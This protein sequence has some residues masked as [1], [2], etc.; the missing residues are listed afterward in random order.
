MSAAGG[1]GPDNAD[2]I[3]LERPDVRVFRYLRLALVALAVTSTGAQAD[4]SPAVGE[5]EG[6]RLDEYRSPTPATLAGAA[7][8]DTEAL[9]RLLASRDDVLLIDVLPAPR[10]PKDLRPSALW[11][12][13]TRRNIPGS[14]WLPNTGYGVLPAEEDEYFRRNLRRLTGDHMDHPLVFYCLADCWMSWNAAKR[15][16]AWGYGKVYW[17]PDGTDGWAAAGL[18]LEDSEPVPLE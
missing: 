14:I 12:P 2:Q 17:Y 13:K 8:V 11:L 15:A 5:P 4:E 6:Y 3:V 1:C 7:T 9:R 10:K 16:V 18:S